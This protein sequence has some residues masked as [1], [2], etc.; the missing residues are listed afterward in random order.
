MNKSTVARSTLSM[1]PLDIASCIQSRWAGW[2]IRLTLFSILSVSLIGCS[3]PTVG[4]Q[5][6]DIMAEIDA[7]CRKEGLGPYLSPDEPPRS[8]KRTDGSCEILKVKPVDPLAIEEGRF[9]Y[10]IKLPPPHDTPKVEYE[11]GMS[12]EEYFRE[13]CEKE[14]GEFVF[15]TVEGVDGIKIMRPFPP[16]SLPIYSEMTASFKLALLDTKASS[17]VERATGGYSYVDAVEIVSGS[18][19]QTQLVHYYFDPNL[20]MRVPPYGVAQYPISESQTRYGYTFRR[21]ALPDAARE[22]GIV[23]G[24]LI[25]MD[26]LTKEVLAYR[27]IFTLMHFVDRQSVEVV[28]G[29]ICMNV[30]YQK[31]GEKFLAEVLKPAAKTQRDTK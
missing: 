13:L 15:R 25:I 1:R 4:Q 3:E 8:S 12:A 23:G 11:K 9:A 2:I 30:A 19:D 6:R 20:P 14:A 21:A 31:G 17:L 22:I 10:S 7:K 5:F 29:T 28:T 24:E 27:R 16:R 18:Q 26:T